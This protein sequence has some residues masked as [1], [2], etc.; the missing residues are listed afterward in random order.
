MPGNFKTNP[1][2]ENIRRALGREPGMSAGERPGVLPPRVPG[3]AEAEID[4]LLSEIIRLSGE[5][6]RVAGDEIEAALQSLVREQGVQRATLWPTARLAELGVE[7]CL[8]RLGVEIISP[9]A[10]KQSLA[11]CDLGVTE[12]DFALPETGTLALFSSPEKPRAVSLLPRVHLAVVH[13]EALRADLHPIFAEARQ[14]NYMILITGP[15][16]TSDIE[17]TT[18][19]GVHG[20]KALYVW[21]LKR[22]S[23]RSKT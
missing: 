16:R 7:D 4:L 12:A 17:L 11:S 9:H 6:R 13:P 5:A 23:S 8:R 21:V 22:P 15:S 20:P 19:L 10:G 3:D 18:T 14:H 2:L 1:V